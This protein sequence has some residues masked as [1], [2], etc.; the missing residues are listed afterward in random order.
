MPI[1]NIKIN[2]LFAS[3]DFDPVNF[4]SESNV[5]DVYTIRNIRLLSLFI[6]DIFIAIGFTVTLIF[7]GVA[8]LNYVQSGTKPENRSKANNA[9]LWAVIGLAVVLISG[10]IRYVIV[11]T[12][13]LDSVDLPA[14][15]PTPPYLDPANP[16]P[17]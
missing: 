8:A 9:I 1:D 15:T 2:K 7:I 5:E 10:S 12:L 14:A 11:Q 6:F 17:Q 13:G 16:G 4:L 3:T